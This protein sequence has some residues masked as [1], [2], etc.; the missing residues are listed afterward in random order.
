[1]PR[2]RR[3]WLRDNDPDEHLKVRLPVKAG[4]RT[5]VATFLKDTVMPEGILPRARESGFLRRRRQH[6]G[7]RAR[8]MCRGRATTPSRDKIFVCHP[9]APAEEAACAEKIIA[10]LAHRAYRR[11]VGADD[12]SATDVVSTGRARRT[13]ASRPA[14]DWRCRRFWC[15]PNSFSGT[16]FDPPDAAPGSVHR[17]SDIELASRLS[18][19]LWSSIPD[20]ELLVGRRERQA[21]R[22]GGAGRPGPAHAGRS[23]LAVAGQE[24]RRPVA[25][26]AQHRQDP[27]RPG[28]VSE[29][30]RKSAP[31]AAS[32]KPNC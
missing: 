11:P 13:A 21:Q 6:L 24:L 17:I 20:D 5:L 23:P 7:G 19:F 8:S 25:V 27:A 4:T 18:F 31:G 32:R 3:A 26:P 1:M 29:L 22:P 2:R 30:R 28:G 12:L 10:N 14:C 15:R 16:E 9:A